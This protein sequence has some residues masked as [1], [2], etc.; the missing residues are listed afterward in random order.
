MKRAVLMTLVIAMAGVVSADS[1]S[2]SARGN[3]QSGSV[4]INFSA[5]SNFNGTGAQ[6][7][8]RFTLANFDPDIV[9]EG[10]VTCLQ[11]VGDI[12]TIAGIVTNVRHPQGFGFGPGFLIQATDSGK[13]ANTPDLLSF[14]LFGPIPNPSACPAAAPGTQPFDGEIVIQDTVI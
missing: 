4:D 14:Q 10:D 12:A 6:G 5:R 7:S 8:V 11:V 13:F 9:V 3:G 1:N 2:D